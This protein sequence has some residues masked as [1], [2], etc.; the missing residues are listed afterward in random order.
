MTIKQLVEAALTLVIGFALAWFFKFIGV[1]IDEKVFMA[2][3]AGIVLWILKA[4]GL[5]LTVIAF[6][7]ARLALFGR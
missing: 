4:I 2:I 1:E 6:R 3:V 5:E 7:R